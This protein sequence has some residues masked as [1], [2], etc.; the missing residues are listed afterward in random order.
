MQTNALV[1]LEN[2][3]WTLLFLSFFVT[4]VV[5]WCIAGRAAAVSTEAAVHVQSH[6]KV[7]ADPHGHGRIGDSATATERP[8]DQT[9]G[10]HVRYEDQLRLPDSPLRAKVR[11]PVN[12]DFGPKLTRMDHFFVFRVS[13]LLDYTADELTGKNLYTLCHG[14]DANR[15][16]KSHMDR[17]CALIQC[18]TP[19]CPA[20]PHSIEEF[21]S[22]RKNKWKTLVEVEIKRPA[23]S[24]ERDAAG[25]D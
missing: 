22:I 3:N 17:K 20:Q 23:C 24:E 13:E 1:Y 5:K 18:A 2:T 10:R 12:P 7:G 15:L 9:G 25:G 8:R 19:L 6:E 4:L 14:E 11:K 16:R 21:L